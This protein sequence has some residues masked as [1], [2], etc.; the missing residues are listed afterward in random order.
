[1]KSKR[2]ALNLVFRAQVR[3]SGPTRFWFERCINLPDERG[4]IESD[5]KH[6]T[7]LASI[8]NTSGRFSPESIDHSQGNQV[9]PILLV[10]DHGFLINIPDP[11][12]LLMTYINNLFC[13]RLT[14]C[15]ANQG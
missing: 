11:T 4:H 14:K 6:S 1:M 12:N 10:A 9:K 3:V 8:E 2:T 13:P 5:S 15:I 7:H